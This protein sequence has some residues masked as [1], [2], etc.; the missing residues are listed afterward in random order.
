MFGTEPWEGRRGKTQGQQRRRAELSVSK[1][2]MDL[3]PLAE[4]RA[5]A[6]GAD[7]NPASPGAPGS[8]RNHTHD[9]AAVH[10]P[11]RST[12]L[13][14]DTAPAPWRSLTDTQDARPILSCPV[15]L[16]L[17]LWEPGQRCPSRGNSQD[18]VPAP[19]LTFGCPCHLLRWDMLIRH[20]LHAGT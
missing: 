8:A 17:P 2:Q 12:H 19:S 20:P 15:G 1:Q 7:T 14:Q 9:Q 5:M 3:M 4:S 18:P 13:R 16:T 11:L 6:H 10:P